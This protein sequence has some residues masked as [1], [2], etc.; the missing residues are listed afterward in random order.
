MIV[1]DR[2]FTSHDVCRFARVTYRQLD[3]WTRTGR[4]TPGHDD[5][6]SRFLDTGSGVY[7]RWSF[8]DLFIVSVIGRLREAHIDFPIIDSIIATLREIP[9]IARIEAHTADT[10]IDISVDVALIRDDLETAFKSC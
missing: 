1:T 3:Y 5:S 9:G 7:R 8:E 4:V 6:S 2:S 10:A